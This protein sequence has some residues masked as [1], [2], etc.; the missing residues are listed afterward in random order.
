MAKQV[1]KRG[2]LVTYKNKKGKITEVYPKDEQNIQNVNIKFED[3][4]ESCEVIGDVN[5]KKVVSKKQIK[6]NKKVLNTTIKTTYLEPRQVRKA[7]TGLDNGGFYIVEKTPSYS[8][9]KIYF[10]G[11]CRQANAQQHKLK[12][13]QGT[14]NQNTLFLK[15]FTLLWFLRQRLISENTKI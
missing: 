13:N 8:K 12:R 7:T 3:G 14:Q 4:S 9:K 1:F 10:L 5:L 15:N 6:T 2:T 11:F